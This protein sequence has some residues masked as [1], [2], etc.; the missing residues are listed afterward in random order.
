[1]RVADKIMF[2]LLFLFLLGCSQQNVEEDFKNTEEVVYMAKA[3]FIIAPENF[4]DEEY[5]TPKNV[6]EQNNIEVITASLKEEATSVAGERVKVD[7]LLDDADSNYDAIV[8]IGGGGASVFFDNAKA[9]SLAKEFFNS[10]KVTAA[11]CIAPVTLANAGVLKGKKA[12]V[13]NGDY[14]SKLESGGA[15]YTGNNVEVD[16]NI[17]TAN[18]PGAAE[19]FGNKLV[20][21]IKG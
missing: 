5:F 11:I 19:E 2:V 21:K 4:K 6:L 15:T 3:L 7:L 17:V 13:W 9:H 20:E 16:G 14:V 12:T 8:F 1:M 18:G 10:G